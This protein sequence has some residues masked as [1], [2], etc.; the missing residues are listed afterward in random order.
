MT[1]D[2][3]KKIYSRL[4]RT[5]GEFLKKERAAAPEPVRFT[6]GDLDVVMK[7]LPNLLAAQSAEVAAYAQ[8]IKE[9]EARIAAMEAKHENRMRAVRDAIAAGKTRFKVFG[10]T[11]DLTGRVDTLEGEDVMGT[12]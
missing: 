9:L 10:E 5:W 2:E 11:F 8:R 3:K 4:C 1:E 12:A 6:K 7:F